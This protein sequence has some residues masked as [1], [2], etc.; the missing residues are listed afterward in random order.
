MTEPSFRPTLIKILTLEILV[1]ALIQ[2]ILGR[3]RRV[4]ESVLAVGG[5][6]GN[7]AAHSAGP[8]FIERIAMLE[9]AKCAMTKLHFS[10]RLR[11][12]E[13]SKAR[14]EPESV[15]FQVGDLVYFY[16]EKMRATKQQKRLKESK[17][18]LTKRYHGPA[19]ACGKEGN[20]AIYIGW[21]GG[22]TKCA[23]EAVRKA[24]SMEAIAAESWA[25]GLQEILDSCVSGARVEEPEDS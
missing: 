20:A 21:R 23:P 2:W 9:T 6:V 11:E 18:V 19:M 15:E 5:V 14:V 12:A 8:D 10:R 17:V 7:L 3:A 4:P 1:L 13:I 24:S 22:I 25:A 16:R